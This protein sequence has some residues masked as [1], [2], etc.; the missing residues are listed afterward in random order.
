MPKQEEKYISKLLIGCGSIIAGVMVILYASF[1]RT[2]HDDWYFW[3]VLAS[4]LLCGGVYSMMGAF[5]HK[6]KA[7]MIRKQKGRELQKTNGGSE[8]A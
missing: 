7:D 5:V 2:K 4:L 3:G 8:E 6:I 1:E